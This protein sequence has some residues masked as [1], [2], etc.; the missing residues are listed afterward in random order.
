[1]DLGYCAIVR[2]E[3]HVIPFAGECDGVEALTEQ[4]ML[5]PKLSGKLSFEM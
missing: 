2:T 1:M 4:S 3:E 5:R